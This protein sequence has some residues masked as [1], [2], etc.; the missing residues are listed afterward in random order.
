MLHELVHM[1]I[2]PHSAKFYKMLDELRD[3]CEKLMR[4]G[5]SIAF[6][7]D[8]DSG[9][10]FNSI[11]N[12][13]FEFDFDFDSISI[14]ISI[15]VWLSKSTLIPLQSTFKIDGFTF[16]VDFDLDDEFDLS[17]AFYF[18][19]HFDFLFVY[20]SPPSPLSILLSP[21]VTARRLRSGRLFRYGFFQIDFNLHFDFAF[22]FDIDFA[23]EFDFDFAFEFIFI[24]CFCFSPFS[25][26]SVLRSPSLAAFAH[27]LLVVP[28]VSPAAIC[29]SR[30][31]VRSWE[32]V[33]PQWMLEPRRSR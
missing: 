11:L 14:S 24:F 3:E 31:T 16:D 12:F 22:E 26:L 4:E 17:F 7:S 15:P 8:F 10:N 5:G 23:F 28:Q 2:G 20:N 27:L 18:Y 1:E 25:S 6:D 33:E 13:D 32:A 21:S 29:R 30:G 9:F 19:L